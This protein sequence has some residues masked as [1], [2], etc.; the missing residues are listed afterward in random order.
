MEQKITPPWIKGLIISLALILTSVI[1]YI[2]GQTTNKSLGWLNAVIIIGGLIWACINYAKQSN[3]NVTFGN[4]FAHGFKTTA[5]FTV[6]FIIYSV[7]A[8]K[9]LFPEMIDQSMEQ[10]RIEM[11]KKGNLSEDQIEQGLSMA[12]RF[13]MPFLI[14]GTLVIFAIIGVVGSVLGAAFAK[15]NPNY[16]PLQ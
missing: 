14:G 3:G 9:F 8:A 10:A 1:I 5:G 12:K 6:I 4:V 16:N 11:E 2:A 7:I 13:F 15:K